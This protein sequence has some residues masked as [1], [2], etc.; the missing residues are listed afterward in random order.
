MTVIDMNEIITTTSSSDDQLNNVDHLHWLD[1]EGNLKDQVDCYNCGYRLTGLKSEGY[2]PECGHSIIQSLIATREQP[3]LHLRR[4][5][6]LEKLKLGLLIA[7]L[8]DLFAIAI[9]IF[10]L[11]IFRPFSY[12]K[13]NTTPPGSTTTI[14]NTTFAS[15]PAFPRW[16]ELIDHYAASAVLIPLTIVGYW[17]ATTMEPKGFRSS[18]KKLIILRSLLLT[19]ISLR[20]AYQILSET[21]RI[22][23]FMDLLF[24]VTFFFWY[25]FVAYLF[26]Y[27]SNLMVGS[28]DWATIKFCRA[29]MRI[30]FIA[31]GIHCLL[32]ISYG[33]FYITGHLT[34]IGSM[35][36][37]DLGHSTLAIMT[38]TLLFG[39]LSQMVLQAV[40][41]VILV[42][43]LAAKFSLWVSFQKVLNEH[44]KGSNQTSTFE[45]SMAKT[46]LS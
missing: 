40:F 16:V 15:P 24:H 19:A 7:W 38:Q 1:S 26:G 4:P 27:F 31:G 46:S 11:F 33:I 43:T 45:D 42:A 32:L 8:A 41:F 29:I 36:L 44:A 30:S 23:F 25:I 2:C 12:L 14:G 17:L 3:P 20:V 18:N 37:I 34:V 9:G 39:F 6:W 13:L 22:E 10:I 21:Y 28:K 35:A 5:A